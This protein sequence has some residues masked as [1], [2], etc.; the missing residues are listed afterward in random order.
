MYTKMLNFLKAKF[1]KVLHFLA[2]IIIMLVVAIFFPLWVAFLSV[3]VAALAKEAR[4][5]VV[6]RGGDWRDLV[7]TV[8]GGLLVWVCLLL[9]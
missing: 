1:D 5:H 9:N 3:C 7:V 6:Y 2:G 8:A 4:D